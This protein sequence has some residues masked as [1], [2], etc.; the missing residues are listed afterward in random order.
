MRICPALTQECLLGAQASQP[1]WVDV[2][3]YTAATR[4]P[5]CVCVCV[6][7]CTTICKFIKVTL[8]FNKSA[9]DK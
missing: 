9:T 7:V 2:T 4:L 6:R 1:S 8:Q 3:V 5:V